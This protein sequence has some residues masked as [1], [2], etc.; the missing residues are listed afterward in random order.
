MDDLK[1][2]SPDAALESALELKD[3][4]SGVLLRLA[5]WDGQFEIIKKPEEGASK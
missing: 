1:A 2:L 4:L 3:M 5:K